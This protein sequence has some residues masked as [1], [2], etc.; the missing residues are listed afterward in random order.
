MEALRGTSHIIIQDLIESQ[1]YE[2]MKIRHPQHPSST[3]KEYLHARVNEYISEYNE[4][5][6]IGN[7]VYY[8]W[9]NRLIH[10]LGKEEFT[11]LRTNRNK[12]KINDEEQQLLA[13]KKVGIAGLSVGRSIAITLAMERSVGELRLADFDA[14]ELSNL[15]RINAPLNELGLNKA[16]AAARNIL[17]IDPYLKVITYTDGLHEQNMESFF[18]EEGLLDLFI[19]ECDGLDI[20]ILS[21]Y[22]ARKNGVPVFMEAS[23]RCLIDVERFDEEPDRPIL[24]GLVPDLDPMHLKTLKTDE[25][26]LPYLV[27]IVG[28]DTLSVRMKASMLEIQQTLTSW[29]Q[30]A[31]DVTMGGG[32]GGEIVRNIL[33]RRLTGSGRFHLDPYSKVPLRKIE[34]YGRYSTYIKQRKQIP[35]PQ[36]TKEEIDREI[37]L[38]KPKHSKH[39]IEIDDVSDLKEAAH[40]APSGGNIQPWIWVFRPEAVYLF[41]DPS[42][43]NTYLDKNK[44]ASLIAL[45]CS[46]CNFTAKA[47]E[48]GYDTTLRTND[49]IKSNLQISILCVKSPK[50]PLR[51]ICHQSIYTRQTNRLP[52]K[53]PYHINQ[54]FL[55]ELIQIGHYNKHFSVNITCTQLLH[56]TIHSS[57]SNSDIQRIN[58]T[59]G[60]FDLQNEI[61]WSNSLFDKTKIGLNFEHVQ[62]NTKEK[63]GFQLNLP[64]VVN[65]KSPKY[66]KNLAVN[67]ISQRTLKASQ[68]FCVLTPICQSHHRKIDIYLGLIFQKIWLLAEKYRMTIQPTNFQRE[69]SG[70][71]HGTPIYFYIH[72]SNNILPIYSNKNNF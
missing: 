16:I 70:L 29:P 8:N 63:T 36:L 60:Y 17:E 68:Y 6:Q 28:L 3:N 47:E 23:D 58:N 31:S 14:L 37:S 59:Q 7:W 13:S 64:A 43:T 32:I 1:V 46:I 57:I 71:I 42:K 35:T 33:L 62:L 40:L 49:I 65:N 15:N 66:N 41:L 54:S 20:K 72:S 51:K 12:L 53:N 44:R 27:K 18:K 4:S 10:I 5:D 39:H 19:E 45:G 61:A 24:H 2:L 22:Y 11:E 21:R 69:P 26:K 48:L 67:N 56:S 9:N 50:T 34:P 25:E 55:L 52:N 38:I 30:L